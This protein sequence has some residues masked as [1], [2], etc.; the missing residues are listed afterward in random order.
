MV[1]VALETALE[2]DLENLE[3]CQGE[4]PAMA[5]A[6]EAGPATQVVCREEDLAKVM[7]SPFRLLV[8]LATR[9]AVVLL[10]ALR[11]LLAALVTPAAVAAQAVGNSSVVKGLRVQCGRSSLHSRKIIQILK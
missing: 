2:M 5:T 11:H 4:D 6:L 3:G 10:V 9:A 7:A 1:A 8:A